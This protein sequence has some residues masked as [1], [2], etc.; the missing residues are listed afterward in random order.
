MGAWSNFLGWASN[1][2]MGDNSQ[3]FIRNGGGSDRANRNLNNT[4]FPQ[5]FEVPRTDISSW[6][7]AKKEA[8][9]AGWPYRIL[10]QKMYEKTELNAHVAACVQRRKELT[11][12]RDFVVKNANGEIDKHWT[13]YFHLAWYK[14]QALEY[15]LDADYHGFTLTSIGEIKDGV[16]GLLTNIKRWNVSPDRQHVSIFER[17]PA[18]YS[19][20]DAP[21]DKWHVWMP[22]VQKN[23]INNCGYGLHYIGSAIEIFNRNNLGF[24]ADYN[25]MFG[26]PYR[27]L[28]TPDLDGDEFE[29]KKKAMAQMGH[30]AYLITG[31]QDELEFINDGSRGQGFKTYNDLDHR[32]KSDISKW[33]GGH[34]DF[35]DNTTKNAS[36]QNQN[37]GG[38]DVTDDATGNS[39]VQKA[40]A[41]KR[42]ID[43]DNA[44]TRTNELWIPKLQGLG[45]SIP[46]GHHIVFLN[47]SEERSID[48]QEANR[49]QLWGTLGLTLAQAGYRIEQKELEGKLGLK[50]EK[51][52]F[53]PDKNVLKD[54]KEQAAGK[55]ALKDGNKAR[56]DKPKHT[57]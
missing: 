19:W 38:G 32:T 28:K 3:A 57:R 37:S 21:Y 18:G 7:A 47:D 20:N 29:E 5:S 30:A 1:R 11:L 35:L 51:V 23:G 39:Q 17:S 24:N 41:A 15:I 44:T 12:L 25:E 48:A 46:K 49:N 34:A 52:A 8:E 13:D 54:P 43:G 16:P 56:N 42:M 53:M 45:I 36:G 31:L 14:Q 6:E 26:Q 9:T 27:H 33:Y 50:L 4:I 55:G 10:M 40:I 22:T 2:G